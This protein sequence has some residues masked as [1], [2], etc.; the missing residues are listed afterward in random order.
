V[1][2]TALLG[3]A[4]QGGSGLGKA[5]IY[6]ALSPHRGGAWQGGARLGMSQYGMPWIGSA[7]QG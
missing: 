4:K 1:H 5:G 3:G 6:L 7:R 2:G